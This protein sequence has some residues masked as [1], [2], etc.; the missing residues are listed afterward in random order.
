MIEI[1]K[2]KGQPVSVFADKQELNII[3]ISDDRILAQ[4]DFS[5]IEHT[6]N[7]NFPEGLVLAFWK[8]EGVGSQLFKEAEISRQGDGL[9]LDLC[10]RATRD[11]WDG[12]WNLEP[13]IE[14]MLEQA[15][16]MQKV[17][18]RDMKLKNVEGHNIVVS[19]YFNPEM[20]IGGSLIEAQENISVFMKKVEYFLIHEKDICLTCEEEE[21]EPLE[22]IDKE[23]L[24]YTGLF[25]VSYM[26]CKKGLFPELTLTR[27]PDNEIL[28]EAGSELIR[29]QVKTKQV[30]RWT[31]LMCDF[32]RYDFIILA[33]FE[34]TGRRELPIFFIL[35]FDA[36]KKVLIRQGSAFPVRIDGRSIKYPSNWKGIV[37][38]SE[39]FEEN[40]DAWGKIK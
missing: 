1:K 12:K 11:A 21:K 17:H 30:E 33:D 6:L 27:H 13:Y 38:L 22:K 3:E 23:F 18:V 31:E 37:L 5:Q 7:E 26:L 29:L 34:E 20:T 2:V 4:C 40:R 35:D 8:E 15:E 32:Q 9:K 16:K 39:H 24:G 14:A 28:I 25:A 19:M 36:W 10:L